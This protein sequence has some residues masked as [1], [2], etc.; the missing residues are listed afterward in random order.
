MS[1]FLVHICPECGGKVKRRHRGRCPQCGTP[2]TKFSALL[3]RNAVRISRQTTP[4][5]E[6]RD[7]DETA[8]SL[9]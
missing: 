1:G 8:M 5:P 6:R 2:R 4:S 3:E 7:V 9:V